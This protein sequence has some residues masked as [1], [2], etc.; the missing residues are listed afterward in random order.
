MEKKGNNSQTSADV[1]K[2]SKRKQNIPKYITDEQAKYFIKCLDD[3]EITHDNNE[4]IRK[5]RQLSVAL[6]YYTGLRV[7]ELCSLKVKH[8]NLDKNILI[9]IGGKGD[10]DRIQELN[11]DIRSFIEKYLI[12]YPMKMDDL[13]IGLS[14]QAVHF[15]IQKYGRIILNEDIHPHVLRHSY[16]STMLERGANLAVIQANLGHSNIETTSIYLHTSNKKKRE[17]NELLETKRSILYRW[18]HPKKKYKRQNI[19]LRE[20]VGLIGRKKEM[21]ELKTHIQNKTPIML[22]GPSGTGKSMVLKDCLN[23]ALIFEDVENINNALK[24]I[25][26]AAYADM[27]DE[28][29]QE[30]IQQAKKRDELMDLLSQGEKITV[31]FDDISKFSPTKRKF[32]KDLSEVIH[33]LA[34]STKMDDQNFFTLNT[35]RPGTF[36]NFADYTETEAKGIIADMLHYPN[37][38]E[39]KIKIAEV[40]HKA[41]KNMKQAKIIVSNLGYGKDMEDIHVEKE[42]VKTYH[43]GGMMLLAFLGWIVYKLKFITAPEGAFFYAAIMII[44]IVYMKFVVNPATRRTT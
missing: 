32:V 36:I 14:R 27:S 11:R 29:K 39:K 34:A 40:F 25:V 31:I 7:S 2:T 44:R 9:V 5:R 43:I 4:F 30:I 37:P 42:D 8:I 13:L 10:K 3:E 16:A 22:V 35:K 19:S 20:P 26:W 23:D 6:M 33:V 18:F 21:D 12:K 41:G 24:K 28:T 15:A 17:A 1:K 38:R